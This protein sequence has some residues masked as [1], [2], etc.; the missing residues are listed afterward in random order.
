MFFFVLLAR[1]AALVNMHS[2]G[3]API[4]DDGL[5]ELSLRLAFAAKEL[6]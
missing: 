3:L 5:P 1:Q 6:I 2:H 4:S